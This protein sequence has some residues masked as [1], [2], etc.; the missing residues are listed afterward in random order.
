M[1]AKVRVSEATAN[2]AARA[3]PMEG[4]VCPD[5]GINDPQ[6]MKVRKKDARHSATM[7]RQ[8]SSDRISA[9]MGT[10]ILF[11]WSIRNVSKRSSNVD[12]R[13]STLA[14]VSGETTLIVVIFTTNSVGN[15]CFNFVFKFPN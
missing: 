5:Q 14:L 3:I 13:V 9:C 1:C 6:M 10:R 15:F 7:E 8:K 11:G 2:P 4:G 12:S